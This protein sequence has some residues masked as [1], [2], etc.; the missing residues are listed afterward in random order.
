MNDLMNSMDNMDLFSTYFLVGKQKTGPIPHDA[1]ASTVKRLLEEL[2]TIQKVDVSRSKVDSLGRTQWTISFLEDNEGTHRGDMP[3]FQLYSSLTSGSNVE[4]QLEL[5]ELRK[6]TYKEVQNIS[7]TAGNSYVDSDSKFKLKFKDEISNEIF[8]LPI[9]GTTCLGSTTAKQIITTSTVDTS[10]IGG[11]DT[12]SPHTSVVLLH[13]GA[14]TSS[15]AINQKSCSETAIIIE[16]QLAALPYL[17][18]ISV[19]GEDN[20]SD[21]GGCIWI[22]TF[23][24]STGNPELLQGEYKHHISVLT[25]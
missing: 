24:G 9:N 6:G 13:K 23:L 17:S 8:A 14:R 21:D 20:G 12:V 19:S 18:Q 11:D 4:P 22:V 16:S 7:I 3:A 1:D 10:G 5:L 2:S 15:I 25:T